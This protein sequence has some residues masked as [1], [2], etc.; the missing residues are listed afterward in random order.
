MANASTFYLY[1]SYIWCAVFALG[2]ILEIAND[3]ATKRVT[4]RS[5]VFQAKV[6]VLLG[7]LVNIVAL[8]LWNTMDPA[9]GAHETLLVSLAFAI[10]QASY[11][12]SSVYWFSLIEAS[13]HLL[14][15]V[16]PGIQ[17]CKRLTLI[18]VGVVIVCVIN[19]SLVQYY[20]F[21]Q[22]AAQ[23]GAVI[24]MCTV[25]I[26]FII[27]LVYQVK[28]QRWFR[29]IEET[30]SEAAASHEYK[31]AVVADGVEE[32]VVETSGPHRGRGRRTSGH[33]IAKSRKYLALKRKTGF[34]LAATVLNLLTGITFLIAYMLPLDLPANMV[35]GK[36]LLLVHQTLGG[37]PIFGFLENGL[38]TFYRPLRAMIAPNLFDSKARAGESSTGAT[39]TTTTTT[40]TA[41]TSGS[42]PTQPRRDNRSRTRAR[43]GSITSNSGPSTPRGGQGDASIAMTR[44]VV[45][46]PPEIVGSDSDS[47][48]SGS[49]SS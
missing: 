37:I 22:M 49:G 26:M 27:N 21:P 47:D 33:S 45:S 16:P 32:V 31:S 25:L 35:L 46:S 24:T 15:N 42:S 10:F 41:T 34:L 40:A 17:L 4:R 36:F 38:R 23:A 43:G 2:Y 13:K 29:Q 14:T 20:I 12:L 8:A 3:Y 6:A 39:G 28:A 9:L 11:M 1:Y 19:H 44:L 5:K 48:S 30:Q 7:V 18:M